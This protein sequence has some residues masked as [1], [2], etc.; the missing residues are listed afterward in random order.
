MV[1]TDAELPELRM[2][3]VMEHCINKGFSP[4]DV[5]LTIETYERLNVIQLNQARTMLTFCQTGTDQ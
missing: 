1:G 3:D 2:S 4:D 5:N